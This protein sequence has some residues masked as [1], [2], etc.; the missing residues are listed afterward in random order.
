MDTKL[1]VIFVVDCN[2]SFDTQRVNI[3][4]IL[5]EIVKRIKKSDDF[6]GFDISLSLVPFSNDVYVE[7]AFEFLP[8]EKIKGDLDLGALGGL[9]NPGPA[10][11]DVVKKALVRN[12][13]WCAD[14][15][16]C[17]HP[18]ICF[19]TDGI[20]KLN[21]AYQVSY[22]K[23]AEYIREREAARKLNVFPI[24]V[25]GGSVDNVNL[26]TNHPERVL[27]VSDLTEFGEKFANVFSEEYIVGSGCDFC[28]C[29]DRPIDPEI[30][31]KMFGHSFGED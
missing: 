8:L 11:E 6:Y 27:K 30:V 5:N 20:H 22:E 15:E 24:V 9:S 1:D 28:H 2:S 18:A 23:I 7:N 29:V 25:D 4:N 13:V 10:F 19:I 26:L 12:D 31:K 3:Q 14:G 16:L 21:E 17:Y